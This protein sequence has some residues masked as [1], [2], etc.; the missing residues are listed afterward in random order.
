MLSSSMIRN[1]GLAGLI[2]LV[3]CAQTSGPGMG[4]A[5]LENTYWKLVELGG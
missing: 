5:P 1:L 2:A 4:G 3:G